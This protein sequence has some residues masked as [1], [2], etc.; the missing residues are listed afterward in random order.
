MID[1]GAID[2]LQAYTNMATTP[3]A[4]A[5]KDRPYLSALLPVCCAGPEVVG[6]MPMTVEEVVY[7]PPVTV[8]ET[9][10]GVGWY[11]PV[12]PDVPG[13][14]LTEGTV[15]VVA[16]VVVKVEPGMVWP[17]ETPVVYTAGMV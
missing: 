15:R 1:A 3:T 14:K 6:D 4:T 10:A 7:M 2:K 13:A 16:T 12:E 5:A 9:G 17:A 8:A 11:R